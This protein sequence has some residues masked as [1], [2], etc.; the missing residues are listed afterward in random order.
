MELTYNPKQFLD[1][2][3]EEKSDENQDLEMQD[4]NL[5]K[6]KDDQKEIEEE[7]EDQTNVVKFQTSKLE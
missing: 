3:N 4:Q 2:L 1:R 7:Q 6:A 5:H